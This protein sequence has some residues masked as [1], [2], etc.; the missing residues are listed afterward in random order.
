MSPI[1]SSICYITSG[2]LFGEI[3]NIHRFS[4]PN[5]LLAFAVLDTSV[6]QSNN[7]LA[8]APS[9]PKRYSRVLQYTLVNA[10]WNVVKNTAA[11]KAHYYAKRAEGRSHYNALRHCVG[12]LVRV[13][14]KI[15]TDKI[16]F[17]L[18]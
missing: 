10:A 5:K 13:I 2:M 4:N 6:C 18:E 3:G 16:E 11:F 12:K 1:I 15:L 8:K 7:F 17:N 9:M 14:W